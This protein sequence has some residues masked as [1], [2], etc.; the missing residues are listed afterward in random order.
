M[1]DVAVSM[2]ET[3]AAVPHNIDQAIF[4]VETIQFHEVS[5]DVADLDGHL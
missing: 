4:N 3:D 2:G 5:R 1:M